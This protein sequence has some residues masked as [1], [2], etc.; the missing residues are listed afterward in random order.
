MAVD[1]RRQQWLD[2]RQMTSTTSGSSARMMMGSST[3]SSGLVQHPDHL[4]ANPTAGGWSTQHGP[5]PRDSLVDLD[6]EFV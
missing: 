3:W 4:G 2:R 1:R 6:R 5:Y